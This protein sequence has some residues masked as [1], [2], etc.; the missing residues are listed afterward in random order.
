LVTDQNNQ[1]VAGV[2]VTATYS[3]PNNGQA[4][5]VTGANGIVTLYTNWKRNPRGTWC[6]EITDVEK[7]GYVY[8]ASANL[9]MLQCE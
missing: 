2:L 3:G 4:S 7:D 5:G 1:P 8:N 6:F 9:I